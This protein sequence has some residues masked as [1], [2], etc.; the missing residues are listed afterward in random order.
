MDCLLAGG[1]F[2]SPA[3]YVPVPNADFSS[4]GVPPT[5]EQIENLSSINTDIRKKLAALLENNASDLDWRAEVQEVLDVLI[6]KSGDMLDEI[7][8]T[9]C[10]KR[11]V[12]K[13]T[14]VVS[15]YRVNKDARLF[16]TEVRNS[17]TNYGEADRL[18]AKMID[19]S[20][21]L[22]SNG[23]SLP[24]IIYNS[25]KDV[26]LTVW[27]NKKSVAPLTPRGVFYFVIDRLDCNGPKYGVD[28][29][30]ENIVLP[31]IEKLISELSVQP[32]R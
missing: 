20:R 13:L 7:N 21:G 29:I 19:K 32:L 14:Q 22:T 18:I 12:K 28:N 17:I 8:N 16:I 10:D 15:E 31:A 5:L 11:F 3:S 25:H 6:K 2:F 24:T 1:A 30:A 4:L 9:N 23:Y 26:D 27:Q